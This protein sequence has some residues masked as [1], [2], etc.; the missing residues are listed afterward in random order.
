MIEKEKFIQERKKSK[1]FFDRIAFFFPIIEKRL[2]PDYLRGLKRLNLSKELSVLD[3]ATGTGLLAEAFA[4]CGHNPVKGVDFSTK[5]L[6][7]AAR[8]RPDIDFSHLDL[9]YLNKIPDNSFDIVS[10]GYFLHG[11]SPDFRELVLENAARISRR[12]VVVFDYYQAGNLFIRFI[13]AFEGPNYAT[14]IASS[15]KDEFQKAGLLI[16]RDT[17]LSSVCGLWLC[18]I[19]DKKFK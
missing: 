10:M 15:R 3:L 11:A 19:T 6:A 4:L 1:A 17:R 14:F 12:Y 18:R 13:E 2:G 7:R 8:K 16:E 9:A 5:M